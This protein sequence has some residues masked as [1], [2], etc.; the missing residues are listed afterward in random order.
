MPYPVAA[1]RGK[2]TGYPGLGLFTLLGPTNTP[3]KA[4]S[5]V[6]ILVNEPSE[7]E[8]GLV[9][10]TG[11]DFQFYGET[12]EVTD[13]TLGAY[14]GW[15]GNWRTYS[16][17]LGVLAVDDFQAADLGTPTDVDTGTGWDG[18]WETYDGYLNTVVNDSFQTYDEGDIY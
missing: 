3:L 5:G 11:D 10:G 13:N 18:A 7:T 6:Y 8:F 15:S 12:S 14:A 17:A 2:N 16:G 4:S 1:V 9:D